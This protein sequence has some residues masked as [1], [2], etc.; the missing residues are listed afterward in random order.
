MLGLISYEA[1]QPDSTGLLLIPDGH[2][3][4]LDLVVLQVPDG[5]ADPALRA[6]LP[7]ATRGIGD[8]EDPK[9]T[10]IF[11]VGAHE[12]DVTGDLGQPGEQRVAVAV[13][14]AA[15][16]SLA[17]TPEGTS[18]HNGEP[19]CRG[20]AICGSYRISQGFASRS[21]RV[22]V[23]GGQTGEHGTQRIVANP[24]VVLYH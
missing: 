9:V 6:K 1:G 10:R 16:R 5:D 2:R 12:V 21:A 14:P 22:Q 4:S 3:G 7:S 19:E 13:A 20:A 11:R 18:Q 17:S 15:A 23:T 8:V 24:W